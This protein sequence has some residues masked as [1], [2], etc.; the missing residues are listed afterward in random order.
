MNNHSSHDLLERISQ[1][2]EGRAQRA[3]QE[4]AS[5]G[6][7]PFVDP[8][9]FKQDYIAA[10]QELMHAMQAYKQSSGRM[11]P[12]WSQVLEVLGSIGYQKAPVPRVTP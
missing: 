3:N 7:R 6:Q 5:S 11:F 2:T 12:T 10:T 1:A 8:S 9:T 4:R